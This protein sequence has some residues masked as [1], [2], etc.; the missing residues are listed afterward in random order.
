[1]TPTLL[2]FFLGVLVGVIL[3]YLIILLTKKKDRGK[4]DQKGDFDD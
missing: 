3:A 2:F 4:E 1:M